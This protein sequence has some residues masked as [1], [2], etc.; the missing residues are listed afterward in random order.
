MLQ[1]H[2]L[3]RCGN[4]VCLID[5]TYK[6]TMYELP[7][8]FLCVPT[9]SSYTVVASIVTVDEQSSS[10]AEA[11][12]LLSSWNPS[13]HPRGFMSDFSESQ[14]KALKTVFPSTIFH[15]SVV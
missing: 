7:L 15:L 5:A 12:Q 13:W 3:L 6:K 8:F 1:R 10:I 14:M 11:L 9:N 2:L 4:E